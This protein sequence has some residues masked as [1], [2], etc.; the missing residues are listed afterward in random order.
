M[1]RFKWKAYEDLL[2]KLALEAIGEVLDDHPDESFY[3]ASFHGFYAEEEGQIAVPLLGVNSHEA[4]DEGYSTWGPPDWYWDDVPFED[5]ELDELQA[6]MQEEACRADVDHWHKTHAR[7]MEAMVKVSKSLTSK[8]KNKKQASKDFVVVVLDEESED[9]DE[10]LRRCMSKAKYKKLFPSENDSENDP[11]LTD[12]GPAKPGWRPYLAELR[13]HEDEILQMGKTALPMLLYAMNLPSQ[14]SDAAGMLG[15]LQIAVPAVIEALRKSAATGKDSHYRSAVSLA[16][17]GD[18]D[19]L[20][21]LSENSKTR[22]I[23]KSGI[24]GL[25]YY[26]VNDCVSYLPLDYRPIERYFDNKCKPAI[27]DLWAG[28]RSIE[29]RDIEE[30]LRGLESRHAEI[31]IHAAEVLSKSKALRR[32]SKKFL[33]ALVEQL[34]DRS[35]EV[36][37]RTLFAISDLGKLAKPYA[38]EIR[39]LKKDVKGSVRNAAALCLRF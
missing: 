4:I 21:E 26:R 15:Q 7:F 19:F 13:A 22:E 10:L 14:R 29:P 18:F 33:P 17:L 9:A 25:Y 8:L 37:L 39:K 11:P 12:V 5:D 38:K 36:R 24:A 27:K 1:A 2:T 28:S 3:A 6:A 20:F 32:H 34:S 23:V 30:A 35:W 16:I 31:R